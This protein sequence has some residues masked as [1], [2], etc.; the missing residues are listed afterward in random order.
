M[1][2]A[3]HDQ[4]ELAQLVAEI[5]ARPEVWEP[6][7]HH[8]HEER[9]CVA[10]LANEH[11]GIWVISWLPGHDTGWHDHAGSV[12]AVAVATGTVCEERPSWGP[13]RIALEAAA[14]E[15]F[16]FGDTDIHRVIAIGDQP[17]V[18]IHAYSPPLQAMGIYRPDEHGAMTR[19]TI[20]WEE[21]LA[22]A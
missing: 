8:D 21:T 19:S 3:A 22:A 9:T 11:V 15:S 16:T 6:L 13:E 20:S 17:A 7:V 2:S 10:L 12:G 5:A 18:T 14:R 4:A 1:A